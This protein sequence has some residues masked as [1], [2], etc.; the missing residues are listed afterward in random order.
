[1]HELGLL[2]SRPGG[3]QRP[4]MSLMMTGPAPDFWGVFGWQVGP[5]PGKFPELSGKA[6]RTRHA[7]P[8][9][10][11]VAER[12]HAEQHLNKTEH[13]LRLKA[14]RKITEFYAIVMAG[15]FMI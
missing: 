2:Q 3:G 1:M 6:A 10:L 14:L 4:V 5:N 15:G 7:L 8:A 9:V 13:V 11:K 12:M